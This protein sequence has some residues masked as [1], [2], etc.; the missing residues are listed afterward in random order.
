[1]SLYPCSACEDRPVG[2]K[3]ASVTWAWNRADG[4]RAAYRQ[5]LCVGCYAMRVLAKP[6]LAFN[7]PLTCPGCG[8]MVSSRSMAPIFA[9]SFLPGQGRFDHEWPTCGAC[10]ARWIGEAQL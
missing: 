10:Q 6:L 7:A 3:L 4:S 8:E 1:M 9:T 2:V 5:R